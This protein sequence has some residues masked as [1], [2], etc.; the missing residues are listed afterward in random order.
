VACDADY[1]TANLNRHHAICLTYRRQRETGEQWR[2]VPGLSGR[3]VTEVGAIVAD[4]H[5]SDHNQVAGALLA[6]HRAGRAS[7]TAMILLLASARPLVLALDP[8]DRFHDSRAS[9][10][11]AVVKRLSDLDPDDVAANAL[12]FLVALLGRI[13]PYAFRHPSEPAG[14]IAASDAELE[15]LLS[16]SHDPAHDVPAVAI[17]RLELAVA[18]QDR[19]WNDLTLYAASGRNRS[20]VYP[21]RIARHRQRLAK[22][23]GYVA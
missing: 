8:D 6:A 11:S 21:S 13:R 16:R 14:P 17:A 4:A 18:R 9:L 7:E 22:T 10:W 15:L 12:P 1:I 20:G 19:G 23:L 5:H 3:P 2:D